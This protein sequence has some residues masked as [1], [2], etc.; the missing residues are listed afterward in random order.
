M[1]GTVLHW[2]KH[3][4]IKERYILILD[5]D[6]VMLRPLLPSHLGISPG[7]AVAAFYGYLK[8]P[9]QPLDSHAMHS[10]QPCRSVPP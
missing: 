7:R 3:A 4:E 1:A 2:V 8:V 9:P 6:M 5:S 10:S